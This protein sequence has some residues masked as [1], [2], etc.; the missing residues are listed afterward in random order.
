[1]NVNTH[2]QVKTT[3]IRLSLSALVVL[4]PNYWLQM[5][6]LF[7]FNSGLFTRD[8]VSSFFIFTYTGTDSTTLLIAISSS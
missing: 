6:L 3:H 8:D 4:L 2:N 1:M 5:H 7:T